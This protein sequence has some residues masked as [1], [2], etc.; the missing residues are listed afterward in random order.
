MASIISFLKETWRRRGY[1]IIAAAAVLIAVAVAL[2]LRWRG[3]E[4]KTLYTAAS[5]GDMAPV[6]ERLKARG[7]GYKVDGLSILT[8]EDRLVEARLELA[9][10]GLPSARE[11]GFELFD[12]GGFFV[13]EFTQRINYTRA[14]QAELARTI[15]R[16]KEVDSARVHIALSE[17]G[18]FLGADKKARASVSIKLRPGMGLSFAGA[19]SIAHIVAG[20]VPE[21]KAADVTVADTDGRTLYGGYDV[22]IGAAP[23]DYKRAMEAGIEG[24]VQGMLDAAFGQGRSSVSVSLDVADTSGSVKRMGIAVVLRGALAEADVKGAEDMIK[25]A[26]GFSAERGDALGVMSAARPASVAPLPSKA[27]GAGH[28]A[29]LQRSAP[30][31]YIGAAFV[32]AFAAFAFWFV[33]A[34][35]AAR[36]EVEDILGRLPPPG[37]GNEPAKPSGA[38]EALRNLARRDPRLVAGVLRGWVGRDA[39][40]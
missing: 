22:A 9:S 23:L 19:S 14:L 27:A 37:A 34:R 32:A 25:A 17:P 16:I 7:I 13:P 38:V 10:V 33:L 5:A 12:N 8:P 3:A 1:A 35:K 15:G 36:R 6:I 26:S 2:S 21:L 18:I 39:G 4:Y 31:I 40:Q 11:A 28:N 30:V 24:R 29:P 20:S